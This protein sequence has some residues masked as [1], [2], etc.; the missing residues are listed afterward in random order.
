M[1]ACVCVSLEQRLR[2]K[3]KLP[4]TKFDDFFKNDPSTEYRYSKGY[5]SIE[6][7]IHMCVWDGCTVCIEM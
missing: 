1:G 5:K 4:D 6:N 7:V 3:P 2:L